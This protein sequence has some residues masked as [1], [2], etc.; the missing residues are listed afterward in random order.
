MHYRFYPSLER[1]LAV[2]L[3][4]KNTNKIGD[5][6]P[7]TPHQED[8]ACGSLV[9]AVE[10]PRPLA[11]GTA[12]KAGKGL[13]TWAGIPAQGNP[14]ADTSEHQAKSS[15]CVVCAPPQLPMRSVFAPGCGSQ[16]SCEY[17]NCLVIYL[18]TQTKTLYY[19]ALFCAPVI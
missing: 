2:R 12:C 17:G 13:P 3:N 18:F 8:L 4:G 1:V 7:Q 9:L 6:R 10:F 5:L 15:C 19:N 16:P 14:T 11:W